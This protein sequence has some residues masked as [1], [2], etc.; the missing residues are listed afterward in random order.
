M[1]RIRL[2][3]LRSAPQH[4]GAEVIYY[5]RVKA[6]LE[7]GRTAAI[8][9]DCLVD[10]GAILSV[11]PQIVWTNFEREIDWLY[12]PASGRALP[13]WLGKVTGLG[14]QPIDC[15]IGKIRIQIVELPLAV[16]TPL[17]SPAF[18]ILAK[19]PYDNGLYSQI[20]L[21]LGGRGGLAWK[22]VVDS[23]NAQAWLEQ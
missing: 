9:Q 7:I 3:Y 20:L 14:A 10:T 19:F 13:N 1:P 12:D 16:P 17:R 18:E 8:R 5:E 6:L 11:F 23:A 2:V 4:V 15:R 21:G 22:I